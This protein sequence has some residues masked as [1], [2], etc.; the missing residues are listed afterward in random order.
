VEVYLGIKIEPLEIN[1]Y[2]VKILQQTRI[3]AALD[4]GIQA[5]FTSS[6][7]PSSL[8]LSTSLSADALAPSS[9]LDLFL[10]MI[11]QY[12]EKRMNRVLQDLKGTWRTRNEGVEILAS[13]F[14]CFTWLKIIQSNS[15]SQNGENSQCST[16]PH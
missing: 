7:D 10:P 8:I 15:N 3:S 1:V 5:R 13:M 6:S 9:S 14:A 12:E 2:D 16:A 4:F 11:L